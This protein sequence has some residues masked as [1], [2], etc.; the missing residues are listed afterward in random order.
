MN[1]T[2][3]LNAALPEIPARAIAQHY[4]RLDPRFTFRE[5]LDDGERVIR[6]Y[7]PSVGAMYK[8]PPQ[9]WALV[10]LFDG[11]R[12]CGEVAALYSQQTGIEYTA[13]AI[14]EFADDLEAA[15]F[16]YKT[17]QEKN[18]LLM[19]K[20]SEERR[21]LLKTKSRYGDFSE[22]LFPAVNPDRFLTWLDEYTSFIYTPWFTFV[23]LT[24][25]ALSTGITIT[26]W[27]E[28]GRDTLEF[29][30]FSHKTWG[31]VAQLYFVA[32]WVLFLHEIGHGHACK[33]YGARVPAM[34]FALIYLAPA[35]YT[36][37]TEGEVKGTR[38]QRLVISLAGVWAELMVYAI[39]TPIWW[40]TPPDTPVHNAA[41]FLMLITGIAAALVNWNPLIKLDGYYMLCEILGIV[42]LKEAST[43][44]VSGWVKR[45][46]W[47]LPVEVPYVPKRRRLGYVAYA[48]L[49]GFY[50]YTVLYIVA[51]FVGNVFRNFNPEWSFVPELA[52]AGLIFR[53]RIRLLVN[54]M[55]F[56]YL[57]KKD[58]V[59]AWFTPRR[60]LAIA[61]GLA[62]VL[63]LP[64]RRDSVAGR[65]ILEPSTRAVVHAVVPG[66]VTKVY[67]E[68]GESV[69]KGE[70]LL[71]LRNLPLQSRLA[72][73]E[74]DYIVAS[75][76]ARSAALRY[77]NFGPAV[78]EQ[79]RLARQTSELSSEAANLELK[80]PISGV[81][82][83]P[84]VNDRVGAYVTEGTE[85]AE[86]A[87][88]GQLRARIY[89]SEHDMYKLRVGSRASLE[90]EGTFKKRNAQ[91]LAISPV[92][93]EIDPGLTGQ[94]QYK[95]MRPPNFYSADLLVANPDGKL[96][97]GMNGTARVYGQRR[98]LA[99]FIL[100]EVMNF[101]GRKV[102]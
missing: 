60:S 14:R 77:G 41:Y 28:I 20:S 91:A 48:L 22:I 4:P 25:F 64:L 81:V 63:L 13:E 27:S 68:E 21:K 78:K 9:N 67:A 35:F 1:I 55:K 11:K 73:V 39:V 29:Y 24:A 66:I 42:D 97:P 101:V 43:A 37:T 32:V 45:H 49:S 7:I 34:G 70:P 71:Q 80:S 69:V 87:D 12:T 16:W 50:S 51:R 10:Q 95:G 26:H 2:R 93:T 40:G 59:R 99:G 52:T 3:A 86:V 90:V 6:V 89:V 94:T 74:A 65:F 47:G 62:A 15:E 72:H 53:S 17:S 85:L 44:Y 31:D 18:I 30:N 33:H 88:L 79:E 58:R 83:T 57:D 100:Q 8:F 38:Y 75:G 54:F 98:S 23:T 5:H 56:V 96:K 82:L 19:Q 102:W 36:D 76:R 46:I 92:S 61:A 84:R